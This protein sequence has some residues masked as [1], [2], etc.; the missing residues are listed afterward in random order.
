MHESVRLIQDRLTRR[1]TELLVRLSTLST[2]TK[3]LRSRT[4]PPHPHVHLVITRTYNSV[5]HVNERLQGSVLVKRQISNSS[6][7]LSRFKGGLFPDLKVI[8]HMQ[9]CINK[10]MVTRRTGQINSFR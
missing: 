2:S 1:L 8:R 3:R 5:I 10:G 4:V 9:H 6:R 7:Q